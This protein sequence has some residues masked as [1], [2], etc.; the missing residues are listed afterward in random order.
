MN[1]KL[2]TILCVVASLFWIGDAVNA[3]EKLTAQTFAGADGK[4]N[5]EQ[6]AYYL[7]YRDKKPLSKF[8]AP[9]E[10]TLN[11]SKVLAAMGDELDDLQ[12][13]THHEAPWTWQEL[14]TLAGAG[15]PKKGEEAAWKK[16]SG[17]TEKKEFGDRK[18]HSRLGPFRLR[19][20]SA[21]LTKDV[22]EAKGA[23]VGFTNDRLS[24]GNGAWN[25]Q[26]ILDYPIGFRHEGG[27]GTGQ[28][29]TLEVGPAIE[30]K[31]AEVQ[32]N[33]KKD[34]QELAFN[35]PTVLY[36]T[37]GSDLPAL[38]VIQ[39]KPYLQTDFSGG[40][41]IFGV[42]A[43]VE[44]VGALLG[45]AL[46][47][48][49]FENIPGSTMQYQLRLIPKI[50]YS[51]TERAGKYTTRKVGDDWFRIGGM[52]SLDLRLGGKAFNPLEIGVAYQFLE[53]VSG[54]G[55]FSDLFKA[56][57]T[58]WISEGTGITLEYSKGD[59]PVADKAIDLIT[60]GLEF[61]Y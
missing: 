12:S 36:L 43:S 25:T 58:W 52:V 15:E 26:G 9:G 60:L 59:T 6:A 1:L 51:Q 37:P 41:R 2:T 47:V 57:G 7:A 40:Y 5:R 50:D 13:K 33:S 3:A 10:L 56:H 42:E 32:G 14:D 35:V 4:L 55:D 20:S 46:G 39:S 24:E 11:P 49:G 19:K 8:L 54:S 28:S 61:K 16:L 23:T 34:V 29:V 45:S 44:Y 27:P 17:F 18:T 21:E 53:T 31:L 48:G 38:W 22:Q 30:W